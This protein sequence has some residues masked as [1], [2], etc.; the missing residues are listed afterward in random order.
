MQIQSD[1]LIQKAVV[2]MIR[3]KRSLQNPWKYLDPLIL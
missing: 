1:N 3:M 2:E